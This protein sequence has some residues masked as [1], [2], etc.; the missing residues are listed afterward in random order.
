ML[1]T[2]RNEAEVWMKIS[3]GRGCSVVVPV[4]ARDTI[5]PTMSKAT[6]AKKECQIQRRQPASVGDDTTKA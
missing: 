3:T 1:S 6:D 2:C 4:T 5:S